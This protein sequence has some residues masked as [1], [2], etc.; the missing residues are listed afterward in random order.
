MAFMSMMLIGVIGLLVFFG[1]V[2]LTWFLFRRFNL[3]YE[4]SFFGGDLTVDKIFSRSSR[5]RIGVWSLEKAQLVADTTSQDALRL[6]R[7][8]V[9]TKNFTAGT[10]DEKKVVVYTVDDDGKEIRLLIAP[11]DRMR[12]AFASYVPK[13]AYK[14]S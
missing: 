2:F 6:E 4:Y 12:Q 11:N 8:E 7:K 5:K 9:Q 1:V 14:L 3:E 13:T 10:P